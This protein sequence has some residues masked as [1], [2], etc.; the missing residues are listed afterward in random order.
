MEMEERRRMEDKNW[1]DFRASMVEAKMYRAADAERQLNL[2]SDIA[3]IKTQVKKT[4]G[5]VDVLEDEK[6]ER[7]AKVKDTM[8]FWNRLLSVITVTATVVMAIS[9]T[10]MYFKK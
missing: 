9:A 7:E 4:N 1:E 5:R 10:V 8:T 3:E 2:L 6:K